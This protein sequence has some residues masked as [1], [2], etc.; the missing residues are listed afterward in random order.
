MICLLEED[1]FQ[2][3]MVNNTKKLHL[4]IKGNLQDFFYKPLAKLQAKRLGL[5]THKVERNGN[6]HMELVFEGERAVLWK[7]VNWSKSG[8]FFS[9]VEEVV[10]QFKDPEIIDIESVETVVAPV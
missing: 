4:N 9:R 6:G 3:N 10:V 5:H 8:P 2:G 7:M 1:N